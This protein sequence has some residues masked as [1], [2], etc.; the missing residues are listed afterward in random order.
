LVAAHAH[1]VVHRDIKPSNIF[2][3]DQG[4]KLLD[5]GIARRILSDRSYATQPG[6]ALGT[7][8]FM[9]PE[10]ARGH[11]EDVDEQSDLW[12]LG[13]T[14][15]LVLSGELPHKGE[16]VN[17]ELLQAM[18]AHVPP[19]ASVTSGLPE[20]LTAFVDKS[21]ALEKVDR[22]SS[23]LVMQGALRLLSAPRTLL[24]LVPEVLGRAQLSRGSEDVPAAPY[25]FTRRRLGTAAAGATLSLA[26]LWAMNRGPMGKDFEAMIEVAA[27][28]LSTFGADEVQV[29]PRELA[30]RPPERNT[31]LGAPHV[32]DNTGATPSISRA[33]PMPTER[34]TTALEGTLPTT[35][36]DTNA[37]SPSAQTPTPARAWQR[38]P[39]RAARPPTAKTAAPEAPKTPSSWHPLE[40][41]R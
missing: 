20:E 11:A 15:Y 33:A 9:P 8:A 39:P 35:R 28:A 18:T 22:F 41:R 40:H 2:L 17:E 21:L 1:G 32:E 37:T 23:A 29:A 38:A 31:A 14:L 30:E 7:P 13:A 24:E 5:F 10:Q 36:G 3:S 25:F 19:L 16:T 26:L 6:A 4:V 27:R 12:S 34:G